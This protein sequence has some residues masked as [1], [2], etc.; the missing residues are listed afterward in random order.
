MIASLDGAIAVEGRSGALGR[1]A[2]RRVF[3]ALRG[4]ADVIVVGAGT[5]IDEDYRPP[6]LE[7]SA[8][9]S[10]RGQSPRPRLAIVT[11]Q[12]SIDATHRVF[13]D[14]GF[15]PLVITVA[16]APTDRRA[17]LDEVVDVVEAGRSTVDLGEAVAHLRSIGL[18]RALLEGGPSLNGAF[19][20]AGLV[21]EWNLSL[22][23]F[24][25]GGTAPRAATA[26]H[27]AE[28]PPRATELHRLWQGDGLLFGRWVRS[29]E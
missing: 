25:V 9:R 14:S 1:P 29:E 13:A 10:A 20:D 26:S 3:A 16:D 19:L 7:R 12:L 28:R 2:D 27:P 6:G 4:I 24:L 8:A 17:A 21:D 23:P 5:V 11:R 15:R 18:Q 22:A